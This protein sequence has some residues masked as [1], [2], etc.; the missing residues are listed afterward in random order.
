MTIK[1]I[2]LRQERCPMALLLAKRHS[3]QLEP[4]ECLY[5]H[6][7]DVVSMQDIITF[8]RSNSF[9]VESQKHLDF[10]VLHII[11]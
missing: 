9:L 8:L 3:V 2:D 10:Y 1:V 11:K 6:I 4:G 5:I 7:V